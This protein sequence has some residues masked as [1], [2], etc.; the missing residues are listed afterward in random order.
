MTILELRNECASLVDREDE[1]GPDA[2]YGEVERLC[3]RTGND[4]DMPRPT[5]D[6]MRRIVRTLSVIDREEIA[7]FPG[8]PLG[9]WCIL[10]ELIPLDRAFRRFW[11]IR[12]I[13]CGFSVR[14]I[15]SELGAAV[16]A[17]KLDD[18]LRVTR[19]KHHAGK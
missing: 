17:G 19:K 1:I 14:A 9:H 12:S 11:I 18:T 2:F 4:P 6:M 15:R 10:G 13:N 16:E 5:Y 8:L 7:E 3:R